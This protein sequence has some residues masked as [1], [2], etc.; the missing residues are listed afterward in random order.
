MNAPTATKPAHDYG[1]ASRRWHTHPN[2]GHPAIGP[3][4]FVTATSGLSHAHP[5]REDDTDSSHQHLLYLDR[6][7]V[8]CAMTRHATRHKRNSRPKRPPAR[9][10]RSMTDTR[11][12]AAPASRQSDYHT[13]P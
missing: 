9:H 2:F 6:T 8:Q 11:P 4:G 12:P 10:R 3:D 13:H 1:P 7:A 5:V